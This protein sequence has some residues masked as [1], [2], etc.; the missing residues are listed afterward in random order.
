[1]VP[2]PLDTN[3]MRPTAVG[4]YRR[5]GGT[6]TTIEPGQAYNE[7]IYRLD[8][9]Q[10]TAKLTLIRTEDTITI[11]RPILGTGE[12]ERTF[13]MNLRLLQTSVTLPLRRTAEADWVVSFLAG[14][15]VEGAYS[16]VRNNSSLPSATFWPME[17]VQ[18]H[19]SAVVLTGNHVSVSLGVSS[20]DV[21][22]TVLFREE[23]TKKWDPLIV[24]TTPRYLSPPEDEIQQLNAIT[25]A[26]RVTK[27][28]K[29]LY[30]SVT[31]PWNE[32]GIPS[33]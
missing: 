23:E 17:A 20:R 11:K 29:T 26:R 28:L 30:R 14:P 13:D 5:E 6:F 27:L 8:P 15:R 18:N 21:R 25:D 1:M 7:W 10:E 2:L 24:L 12:I 4:L 9:D 3:G 22:A 19:E 33:E 31:I 32:T 16:R